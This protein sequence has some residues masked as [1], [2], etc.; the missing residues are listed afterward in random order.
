[1][2]GLFVNV[3]LHDRQKQKYLLHE[4]V[5]MP[6]HF[7]LLITPQQSLERAMQLIKGGFSFR[8]KRELGF[9]REIWQP[10][11]YDRRVRDAEEYFAFREY[12]RQNPLKRG[13][14]LKAGGLSVQFCL[15]R[16]GAGRGT[17]AAKA[18]GLLERLNRSGKPLRHPK[19][20][21]S[22]LQ[23]LVFGENWGR[24]NWGQ[25]ERSR[26]RKLGTGGTF[27]GSRQ[28]K[29][30]ERRWPRLA[31]ALGANPSA[32]LRAGFWDEQYP[33]PASCGL[34]LPI[35]RCPF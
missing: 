34:P 28:M 11:F 1:M 2:A 20:L 30:S 25:A 15:A 10:S 4:F 17:S 24:E 3:L 13:L 29:S 6:D 27:P 7:H 23:N 16:A 26:T 22:S 12:I 14:A 9:R 19:A 8:V 33:L 21:S 5:V 35:P 32:S 18:G 31:P